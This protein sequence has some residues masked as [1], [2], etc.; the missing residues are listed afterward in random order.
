MIYYFHFQMLRSA[1]NYL[2]APNK[3]ASASA[4]I[5]IRIFTISWIHSPKHTGD[6]SYT[7][8]HRLHNSRLFTLLGP[9]TNNSWSYQALSHNQSG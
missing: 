9:K 1:A 7:G 2:H 5:L 8:Q 3:D 4:F 6:H